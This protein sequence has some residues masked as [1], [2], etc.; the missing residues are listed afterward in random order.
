LPQYEELV[1]EVRAI[2]EVVAPAHVG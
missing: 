1:G 2:H